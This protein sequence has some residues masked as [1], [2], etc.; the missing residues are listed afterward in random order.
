MSPFDPFRGGGSPKGDNVPFF[1]RFFLG[2]LPLSMLFS[3]FRQAMK[4]VSV[5]LEW[6]EEGKVTFSNVKS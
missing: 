6:R 3:E 1:H 2:E 5:R 4:A